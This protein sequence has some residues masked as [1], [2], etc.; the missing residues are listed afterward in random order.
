MPVG[1][2][3]LEVTQWNT[4][5]LHCGFIILSDKCQV[6]EVPQLQLFFVHLECFFE[7]IIL[8]PFLFLPQALEL[9]LYTFAGI[10]YIGFKGSNSLFNEW[11]H[12]L[13]DHFLQYL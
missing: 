5:I 2:A 4:A 3:L 12:L 6:N 7:A 10:S 11:K 9:I 8:S 13:F 1:F